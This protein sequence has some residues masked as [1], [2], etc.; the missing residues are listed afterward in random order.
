M[1]TE[2][3]CDFCGRF[4][5]VREVIPTEPGME[6]CIGKFI[7]TKCEEEHG[8]DKINSKSTSR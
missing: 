1:Y 2:D 7:C 4:R 3:W 8:N 5:L 6:D